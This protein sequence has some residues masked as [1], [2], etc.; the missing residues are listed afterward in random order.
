MTN[1][2]EVPHTHFRCATCDGVFGKEWSDEVARDEAIAK[3]IDPDE[4]CGS[5]CDDCYRLTPWGA[6]SPGSM[7][8][9][10][11]DVTPTWQTLNGF[12]VVRPHSVPETYINEL[13]SITWDELQARLAADIAKSNAEATALAK[14][15][16]NGSEMRAMDGSDPQRE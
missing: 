11:H 3:G 7:K 6:L 12:P 5:V 15:M 10:N 9:S 1:D 2:P 13:E 4:P 14:K 16:S 8:I